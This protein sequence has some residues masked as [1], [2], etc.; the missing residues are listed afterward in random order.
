MSFKKLIE[1]WLEEGFLRFETSYEKVSEESSLV[2]Y[3][4][5]DEGQN[6]TP[7]PLYPTFVVDVELDPNFLVEYFEVIERA[8]PK[9]KEHVNKKVT[10][11]K[12]V[13]TSG[14]IKSSLVGKENI[15]SSI[16]YKRNSIFLSKVIFSTYELPDIL[17]PKTSPQYDAVLTRNDLY[18]HSLSLRQSHPSDILDQSTLVGYAESEDKI[19]QT[20]PILFEEKE[21]LVN[22]FLMKAH[23]SRPEFA[24]KTPLKSF[25]EYMNA[26]IKFQNY[27]DFIFNVSERPDFLI[28]LKRSLYVLEKSLNYNTYKNT[29]LSYNNCKSDLEDMIQ[30]H[31]CDIPSKVSSS[32]NDSTQLTRVK[33]KHHLEFHLSETKDYRVTC[34]E[35]NPK[36]SSIFISG[37]GVQSGNEMSK[38]PRGMVLCWNIHKCEYPEKIYHTEEAVTCVSFSN[39]Q[40]FL[41][42]VGMRYGLIDVYDLRTSFLKPCGSNRS[43]KERPT[44]TIVSIKWKTKSHS[45]KNDIEVLLSISTDGVITTWSQGKTLEGDVFKKTTRGTNNDQ[46]EKH[47]QL[48]LA[49]DATGT[50]LQMKPV[51]PNIVQFGTMEG[52][53]LKVSSE[54]PEDYMQVFEC[55]NGPTYDLQWSPL[56]EDVF[57]TS[58]GDNKIRIW[59]T[60]RTKSSKTI[61]LPET[62]TRLA[63]S[64]MK[65]TV[66]VGLSKQALFVFDLS[67]DMHKP[68]LVFKAREFASFTCA[69][70]CPRNNW[71]LVGDSGGFIS[72]YELTDVPESVRNQSESLKNTFLPEY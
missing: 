3:L 60:G 36:N 17:V 34:V 62:V 2:P 35:C 64:N 22:S 52:Q 31:N 5:N 25:T 24:T 47:R 39:L 12:Y 20:T 7:R 13:K 33:L 44:G 45:L 48:L 63:L 68:V 16:D 30:R 55:H 38:N 46:T 26:K 15:I 1:D 9:A 58:G 71:I 65:S 50:C 57:V 29:L 69:V 11:D 40:P 19:A 67:L 23:Y 32:S 56:V 70:F 43:S 4:K 51:D 41:V 6:I 49:S 14:I 8:L 28:N 27:K 59:E 42:A 54:S 72:L 66:F 53:V 61:A 10:K 18:K 21:C 37:Y